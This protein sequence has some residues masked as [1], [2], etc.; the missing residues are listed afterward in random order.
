MGMRRTVSANVFATSMQPPEEK[1]GAVWLTF[2]AEEQPTIR[3]VMTKQNFEAWKLRFG[4][5]RSTASPC[6]T[7]LCP[8]QQSLFTS[9]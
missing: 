2:F 7:S 3:I 1:D 8:L 5:R 4:M 6:G 9:H